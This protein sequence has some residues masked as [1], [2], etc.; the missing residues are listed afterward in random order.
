MSTWVV[1]LGLLL[2]VPQ[3]FAKPVMG[4]KLKKARKRYDIS[5]AGAAALVAYDV[6]KKSKL[7]GPSCIQSAAYFALD[8]Q[9]EVIEDLLETQDLGA[10]NGLAF[11]DARPEERLGFEREL[12]QARIDE[13]GIA[14]EAVAKVASLLGIDDLWLGTLKG[15]L[16][17]DKPVSN[18][19][20]QVFVAACEK[21]APAAGVQALL[22]S[23]KPSQ[24]LTLNLGG[25]KRD[26]AE[27]AAFRFGRCEARLQAGRAVLPPRGYRGA[28][29]VQF[30][31]IRRELVMPLSVRPDG[32]AEPP[33][34]WQALKRTQKGADTYAYV[35]D[36]KP[37]SPSMAARCQ[38]NVTAGEDI[39]SRTDE[40]ALLVV[41]MPYFTRGVSADFLGCKLTSAGG[42]L[43]VPYEGW[44]ED[45]VVLN[46]GAHEVRVASP[47]KPTKLTLKPSDYPW[48]RG[49]V[50]LRHV[51]EGFTVQQGETQVPCTWSERQGRCQAWPGP[52]T[53][54][55]SA[56]GRVRKA[57]EAQVAPEEEVAADVRLSRDVWLELG[58]PDLAATGG[59]VL[60]AGLMISGVGVVLGK[61]QELK[62]QSG[63]FAVGTADEIKSTEDLGNG[64]VWAGGAVLAAGV[65]VEAGL[66]VVDWLTAESLPEWQE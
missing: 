30:S 40:A 34:L 24:G 38:Q 33:A 32:G 28:V 18:E 56:P 23:L 65:V 35:F 49:T 12:L 20:W 10:W 53:A 36:F 8:H 41:S 17:A 4:E 31:G 3:A 2:V 55:V 58:W 59:A 44:P 64:L 43:A 26:V 62:A 66:L 21:P 5:G 27:D 37:L 39:F 16:A 46:F 22:T 50:V 15:M 48:M 7:K 54:E 51:P 25:A 61:Q 1:G 6:C 45:Q 9:T 47:G 63:A 19:L 13:E 52:F 57:L 29:E 60:G 14:D 11:A 42:T